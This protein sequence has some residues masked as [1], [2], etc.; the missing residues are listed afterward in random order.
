MNSNTALYAL[1]AILLGAVG[2]YFHDFAMQ[3]QPVP[4]GF[5][6]AHAARVRER[7]AA[8]HRR[9]RDPRAA[10]ASA[11][12]RCCSRHSSACGWWRSPAARDRGVSR[13][14]A[15][16]TRPAEFTFMTMGGVALFASGAG[17]HA[18]HAAAASR[19]SW[20]ASA[21][22]VFGFAHFNYIDFTASMVPALDS[23][24]QTVLGLGHRRRPPRGGHRAGERLPGAA[25][26]RAARRR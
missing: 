7:R 12:A 18:R 11:A 24:E 21:P 26:G 17:A 14:S 9:R 15:P 6:D 1:G 5:A 8:H 3:W 19:A 16:G 25:R 23:A 2:I 13:T 10:R 20:P 4:A 22:C